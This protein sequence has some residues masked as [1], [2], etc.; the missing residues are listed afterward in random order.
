MQ[1][2]INLFGCT[3][4]KSQFKT[5]EFLG[6][7]YANL[8]RCWCITSPQKSAAT[9]PAAAIEAA[10]ISEASQAQPVVGHTAGRR[11]IDVVVPCLF[12]FFTLVESENKEGG[13]NQT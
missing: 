12:F 10:I 4:P 2:R 1:Y 8:F 11:K 3:I 6:L 5:S 7:G 9:G 13:G